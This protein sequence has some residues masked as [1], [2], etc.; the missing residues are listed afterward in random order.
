MRQQHV[1]GVQPRIHLHD[2]HTGLGV[3]GFNGAVNGR[4]PAPTRQ[5]GGVD[6]QAAMP[7]R[8]QNPLRQD[9]AIG[10]HHHHIGIGRRDV[11]LRR[12]RIIRKFAIEPQAA[13]LRHSQAL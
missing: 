2:G 9:Q 10:R 13:G 1:A 7:R 8:I 3:A 6:I 5:Q 4:S 11:Q 12:S